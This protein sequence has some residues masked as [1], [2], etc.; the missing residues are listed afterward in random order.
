MTIYDNSHLMAATGRP[1]ASPMATWVIVV[2]RRSYP[3]DIRDYTSIMLIM[4][5]TVAWWF[6]TPLKPID[7]V[8]TKVPILQLNHRLVDP[9]SCF[10]PYQNCFFIVDR[11]SSCVLVSESIVMRTFKNVIYNSSHHSH[12]CWA[13]CS[14]STSVCSPTSCSTLM[15]GTGWEKNLTILE[16]AW[17]WCDGD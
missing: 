2:L 12:Q 8:P 16:Y 11:K 9:W 14:W 13:L 5:M 15:S 10:H 6:G 7:S 1:S 17:I 3:Q 4:S